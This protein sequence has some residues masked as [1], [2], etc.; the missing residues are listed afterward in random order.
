MRLIKET[1]RLNT[2]EVTIEKMD[3]RVWRNKRLYLNRRDY[4]DLEKK[5]YYLFSL[6]VKSS[7]PA[8]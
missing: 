6:F 3:G 5:R 8:K 7:V 2:G 4:V 1:K